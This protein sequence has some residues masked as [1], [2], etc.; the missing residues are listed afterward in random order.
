MDGGSYTAP[1]MVLVG[2][3]QRLAEPLTRRQRRGMLYCGLGVL[4]ASIA[5]VAILVTSNKSLAPAS[6]HGCVSVQVA[7]ATGGVVLHE[8]GTTARSWCRTEYARH[9]RLALAVQPQCRLAGIT[10]PKQ[11]NVSG[12][13]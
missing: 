3:S 6:G 10:A 12:S 4:V 1:P 5:V 7:G 11:T 9:D 2:H 13:R 8:C